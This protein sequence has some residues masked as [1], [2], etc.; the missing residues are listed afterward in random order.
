MLR[1]IQLTDI[2]KESVYKP[3]KVGSGHTLVHHANR[4]NLGLT[5]PREEHAPASYYIGNLGIPE[6]SEKVTTAGVT[7]DLFSGEVI[8]PNFC[9]EPTGVNI[10]LALTGFGEDPRLKT[11]GKPN[12][13]EKLYSGAFLVIKDQNDP[14]SAEKFQEGVKRITDTF[15]GERNYDGLRRVLLIGV[16]SIGG[17]LPPQVYYEGRRRAIET[18][19]L[20]A[21]GGVIGFAGAKLLEINDEKRRVEQVPELAEFVADSAAEAE[22]SRIRTHSIQTK[23]NQRIFDMLK[24]EGVA[25]K[26]LS[27]ERFLTW[28]GT[29]DPFVQ[30]ALQEHSYKIDYTDQGLCLLFELAASEETKPLSEREM[31][32]RVQH[33]TDNASNTQPR[34]RNNSVIT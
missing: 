34:S 26:F 8:V 12:S 28:N 21:A 20:A 5:R 11:P 22:L 2:L 18:V 16:G 32:Q 6:L 15:I 17:A 13:S 33:I 25:R 9:A 30:T 4:K 24:A 19:V 31:R 27:P 29:L 1:E 7:W 23:R 14:Y 10:D 3:Y